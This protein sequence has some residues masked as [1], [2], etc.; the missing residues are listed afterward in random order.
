MKSIG[1]KINRNCIKSK[2]NVIF[3]IK[4]MKKKNVCCNNI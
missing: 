2:I 4:E 3:L 1:K